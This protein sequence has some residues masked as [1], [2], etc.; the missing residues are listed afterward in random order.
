MTYQISV[1]AKE[2]AVSVV[3]SGEVPDGQYEITGYTEGD[4]ST[5]SLTLLDTADKQLV[6]LGATHTKES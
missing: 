1:E 4:Q 5:V 3:A 6:F 2:G